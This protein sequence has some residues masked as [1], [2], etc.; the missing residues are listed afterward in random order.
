MEI[1]HYGVNV[2]IAL[3]LYNWCVVVGNVYKHHA[4]FTKSKQVE[5]T[6]ATSF[7]L[8]PRARDNYIR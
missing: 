3:M 7:V 6:E 8:W 4:K 2:D 5:A 1:V